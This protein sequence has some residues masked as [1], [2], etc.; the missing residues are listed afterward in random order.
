MARDSSHRTHP[1]RRA[2][3]RLGAGATLWPVAARTGAAQAQ[4]RGIAVAPG[5]PCPGDQDGI[6]SLLLEGSGAAAAGTVVSFGQALRPGD[7]PQGAALTART[8]AGRPLPVQTD[9][10]TRHPDGSARFAVVSLAAPG[11]RVG[12][13]LGVVLGRGA[14][15]GEAPLD[16]LAA[17]AGR[18]AVVEITPSGDGVPWRADLLLRMLDAVVLRTPGAVWQWGPLAM[19]A[20]VHLSVP[21][22]ALGPGAA[23]MRLVADLALRSDGTL[24]C[25]VW[26]RNDIAMSTAGGTARYAMRLLV[27][28]RPVLE[29]REVRHLQYQGWG[30]TRLVARDGRAVVPPLVRHD[31]RY[32]GEIGAVPRYDIAVG[33][34]E[35]VLAGLAAAA[36]RQDWAPPFAP[37]GVTQYMP[38]VG[39]RPDI[40]P[41][42]AWQAMWLV[43][44]DAR[45]AAFALG[46]AE[47]AGAVPWHFWD[48][49]NGTWL[50]TDAYPG[51]WTDGPGG[52]GRPG[53][54][55]SGGLTQRVPGFDVSGWLPDPAHQPDLSTVPYLLTGERWILDNLQAQ[56]AAAIMSSR[57][58]RRQH[59][60]GLVVDTGDVQAAA[61]NLRQ[62]GNAAWLSP[63]GSA[64]KAYF[65]RIARTN[66]DWLVA[67]IP[68]WSARQG[69]AHGWI[70]A[71]GGAEREVP[72]MIR[73][74]SQDAFAS[75][76]VLSALRGN[77][78]ARVVLEWMSNFL[79]GRFTS[80][81]EGFRQSLGAA[82]MLAASPPRDLRA[83]F[84]TWAKMGEENDRRGLGSVEWDNAACNR[85]ALASLAG[86][87]TVLPSS[88]AGR[89]FAD[90]S[91]RGLPG[92]AVQDYRRDPS[93]SVV[94]PGVSRAAAGERRA[95][96]HCTPSRP[97]A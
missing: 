72:G 5:L 73:P 68:E 61:W 94:P 53:D 82:H 38:R 14:P 50:T 31:A 91:R 59:G 49:A 34:E 46:Q 58:E 83:L 43:S 90:L 85:L 63:D 21:R 29:A 32:L 30:R 79:I 67:R 33:V 16:V 22:T 15:P 75:I 13:R 70:P 24:W 26:L 95:G 44:G 20:R 18:S 10:T 60:A 51:L 23:E 78:R 76:A 28:G 8:A 12:E 64:E 87:A 19:Q 69:E 36:A 89:L 7:L 48:A 66:W 1:G 25:A 11:L 39:G 52:P 4:P 17:G 54:P 74:W 81:R 88:A 37:R 47:A 3:L 57:P 6:V 77:D 42:T 65:E 40:G 96:P 62:V 97:P 80:E 41:T 27:D 56:A 9:V 86:I 35:P 84:T 71:D 45:A 92:T 93:G 55:R 2:A